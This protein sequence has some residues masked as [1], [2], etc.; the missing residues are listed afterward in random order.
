MRRG[1]LAAEGR[2]I[3]G[4]VGGWIGGLSSSLLG[5]VRLVAEAEKEVGIEGSMDDDEG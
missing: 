1:R 2:S 5:S 4:D 3:I